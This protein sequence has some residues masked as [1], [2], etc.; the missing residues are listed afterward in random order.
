MTLLRAKDFIEVYR[1]KSRAMDI[2][3]LSGRSG[4]PEQTQRVT[5]HIISK[6]E[7]QKTDVVVDIGCGDGSLLRKILVTK[8]GVNVAVGI[9]PTAEELN[10]IEHVWSQFVG[11]QMSIQLGLS[12]RTALPA[13]FATKVVINGVLLHLE[14]EQAVE[15][16]LKEL[17]RI[18]RPGGLLYVGEVPD[19][20]E[21]A[22]RDYGDS[23]SRWLIWSFRHR[24]LRSFWHGLKQVA[25][26]LLT[27]HP[28]VIVPK[29]M[30]WMK[31]RRF[32][33]KL[34]IYGF[35]VIESYRH[36]VVLGNEPL[37]GR[38]R[39]NYVAIR[40]NGGVGT[41][42]THFT[43]YKRRS[44]DLAERPVGLVT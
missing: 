23:I 44:V 13:N 36:K 3:E 33:N 16:T 18:T 8:V 42:R 10:R 40:Q 19:Q 29:R 43:T 27:S 12:T 20:D 35:D 28:F 31:R 6:L 22:G 39:W 17:R 9:V 38:T 32:I 41:Q 5:D 15:A 2:H 11:D 4:N 24:G 26:G 7:L 37:E 25:R 14:N 30:F 21:F 34:R 1:L